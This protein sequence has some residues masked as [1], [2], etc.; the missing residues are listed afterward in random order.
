MSESTA[1]DLHL[2]E[3]STANM[4]ET[5]QTELLTHRHGYDTTTHENVVQIEQGWSRPG[6]L[7]MRRGP[8]AGPD[9][10]A[11]GWEPQLSLGS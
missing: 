10:S 7:R 1:V 3:R 2:T 4:S 5:Q 11:A 6:H 9:P 8:P